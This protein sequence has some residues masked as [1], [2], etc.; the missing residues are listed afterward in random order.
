MRDEFI[1]Y[2]VTGFLF[3]AI[4]WFLVGSFFIFIDWLWF[5]HRHEVPVTTWVPWTIGLVVVA[6]GPYFLCYRSLL[7]WGHYFW[8]GLKFT[9]GK[10]N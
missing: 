1:V 8:L 3:R 4:F 2:K 9:Y 5:P 10:G 6:A 7:R